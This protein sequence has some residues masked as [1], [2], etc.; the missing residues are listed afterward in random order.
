MLLSLGVSAGAGQAGTIALAN[1]SFED[2]PSPVAP[3]T[4]RQFTGGIAGWT[5]AEGERRVEVWGSGF[6]GVDAVDGAAFMELNAT[7]RGTVYQEIGTIAAGQALAFSFAHRG[8]AGRDSMAFVLDIRD[9]GGA[10]LQEL[11]RDSY[12]ADRGAWNRVAGRSATAAQ[13]GTVRLS[14]VSEASARG[15]SYG[16]FVDDVRIEASAVPLPAGVVLLGT[17]LAAL[18]VA[19]RRRSA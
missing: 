11:F 16:N 18:A 7:T 8:R 10:V 2:T 4:W 6:N 1:G 14:F 13:G 3:G 15:P 12:S 5:P 9:A 17:G 19:R